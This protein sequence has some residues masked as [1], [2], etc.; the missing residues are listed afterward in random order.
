[1]LWF[2][3]ASAGTLGLFLLNQNAHNIVISGL[4]VSLSQILFPI[5]IILFFVFIYSFNFLPAYTSDVDG[6]IKAEGFFKNLI[7]RLPKL[8]FAQPFYNIGVAITLSLPL[9]ISF[10]LFQSI[11]IVSKNTFQTWQSN[12]LQLPINSSQISSNDDEVDDY[13]DELNKLES[14]LIN[15]TI[16]N[17]KIARINTE[18]SDANKLKNLLIN[19]NSIFTF[20]GEAYVGET[21]RFSV[22]NVLN[23]TE[24]KWA[25]IN[26]ENDKELLSKTFET[27][28]NNGTY[29]FF[30]T[31]KYPRSY[32]IAFTPS[33]NC[34]KG[35]QKS[36]IV[37]VKKQPEPKLSMGNPTGKVSVCQDDTVQYTAGTLN[38]DEY[39]WEIPKNAAFYSGSKSKKITIILG[40]TP[41]TVRVRGLKHDAA[42]NIINQ[43]LWSGTLV[44]VSPS[45][46][47]QHYTVPKIPNEE[48]VIKSL[49][50]PFLF[51]TLEEADE[52]ITNLN[53]ELSN[54]KNDKLDYI[55]NIKVS[56]ER[57]K[58]R[59]NANID[60]LNE[61][62]ASNR[63]Q[64]LGGIFALFGFALL[65][66]IALSTVWS[67]CISFS[68]D[69]YNFE[70][71]KK[72]YWKKLIDDL[73]SQNPN[74]PL[75]G[76]F[77]L[78][79]GGSI[80]LTAAIFIVSIF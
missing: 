61:S 20:E 72:H 65:V 31:W 22:K 74:Q 16:Y 36:R 54:V 26:P 19:N 70:Q 17:E 32:K 73:K 1:V 8:I 45:L 44:K 57:S 62:T 35:Q 15:T 6:E 56:K 2:G 14:Q 24:Y 38:F 25:I 78:F 4:S 66:S 7:I 41:G 55:D 21:Q 68:F 64:I 76:W 51:Y 53:E 18:I 33:N 71:S 46:G 63:S 43:S 69:L 34:G 5:S 52:L 23:C 37:Y 48:I 11:E 58:E 28:N 30:H 49:E 67:Y 60:R 42:D 79:F 50:R 27:S 40:D 39:E 29:E 3:I 59:I 10:L 9:V 80:Y 12:I 47:L 75:L 13:N 77:V